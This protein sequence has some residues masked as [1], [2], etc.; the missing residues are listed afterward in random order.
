MPNETAVRD[1][2][3]KAAKDST[4]APKKVM[5]ALEKVFTAEINDRLPFQSRARIYQE[6][7]DDGLLQ[8]MERVVGPG[9]WDAVT[10]SGYQLSHAGRYLYC[11]NCVDQDD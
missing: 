10:V 7:C 4:T 2:A 1:A 3:L 9:Q 5:T 11:S 8:P 6:L